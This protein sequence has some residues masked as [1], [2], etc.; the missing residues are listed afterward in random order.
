MDLA[1]EIKGLE[2]PQAVSFDQRYGIGPWETEDGETVATTTSDN[3]QQKGE[4]LNKAGD[5]IQVL[6]DLFCTIFPKQCQSRQTSSQPPVIVQ[7][8]NQRDWLTISLIVV[9]LVVLL[10]LILKK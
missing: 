3:P 10:I 6:P 1:S 2:L 5:V 7:Q 8:S 4:W 9:V